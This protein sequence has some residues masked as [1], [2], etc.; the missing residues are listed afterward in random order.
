MKEHIHYSV[1]Y[2]RE[3]K[4]ASFV[5]S[6][7]V[8]MCHFFDVEMI[9]SSCACRNKMKKTNQYHYWQGAQWCVLVY[10]AKAIPFHLHDPGN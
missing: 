6:V 1:L 7:Q 4:V 8:F 2:Y 10:T 3:R 9:P 5:G